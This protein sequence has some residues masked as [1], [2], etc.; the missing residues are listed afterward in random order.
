MFKIWQDIIGQNLR[1]ARKRDT[2]KWSVQASCRPGVYLPKVA[3]VPKRIYTADNIP[4]L[5]IN[6]V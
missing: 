6:N 5:I 3:G 2:G 4:H 1:R